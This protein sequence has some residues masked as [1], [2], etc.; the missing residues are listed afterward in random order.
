[1]ASSSR[2]RKRSHLKES[3]AVQPQRVRQALHFLAATPGYR[4]AGLSCTWN[5]TIQSGRSGK[6]RWVGA[7]SGY[8]FGRDLSSHKTLAWRL[9]FLMR[10]PRCF[11]RPYVR[12]S[13]GVR[14]HR[15]F[16]SS[17][18]STRRD[19]ASV[20]VGFRVPVANSISSVTLDRGLYIVTS[21]LVSVTGILAALFLLSLSGTWR[22]YAFLFALVSG[23]ACSDRSGFSKALAGILRGCARDRAIAVV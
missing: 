15:N 7:G 3:H 8:R 18:S 9:T 19:R 20:F 12:P 11:V 16:R 13:S 4:F 22:L 6:D 14:G 5:R 21:A 1:M 23:I 10:Y 2:F 17:W